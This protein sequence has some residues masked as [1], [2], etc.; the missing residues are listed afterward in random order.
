MPTMRKLEDCRRIGAVEGI[1]RLM[2]TAIVAAVSNG[3]TFTNVRQFVAWLIVRFQAELR[4]GT[5]LLRRGES[6]GEALHE[7]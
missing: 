3:R 5:A 1:D 2:A 7:R 6:T 4:G